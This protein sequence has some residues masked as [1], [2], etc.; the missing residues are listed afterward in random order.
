MGA[1]SLTRRK[2]RGR[3]G[4]HSTTGLQHGSHAASLH[5]RGTLPAPGGG[6]PALQARPVSI[7]PH[8]LG[9]ITCDLSIP[10]SEFDPAGDSIYDRMCDVTMKRKRRVHASARVC[11]EIGKDV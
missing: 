1:L 11:R 9:S 5:L 10:H 8:F 3:S 6:P 4:L 7:G 2:P